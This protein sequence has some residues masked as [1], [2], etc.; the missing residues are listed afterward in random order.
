MKYKCLFIKGDLHVQDDY[1]QTLFDMFLVCNILY[2]YDFENDERD[3][4]KDYGQISV[5]NFPQNLPPLYK[6]ETV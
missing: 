5:G 3:N 4:V 1:Y 6:Y 2:T